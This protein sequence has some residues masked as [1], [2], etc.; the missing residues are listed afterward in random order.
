MEKIRIPKQE[1]FGF[2]EKPSNRGKGTFKITSFVA[3]REDGTT[4]GACQTYG[5]KREFLKEAMEKG[6]LLEVEWMDYKPQFNQFTVYF[7]GG[8]GSGATFRK[9]FEGG[10]GSYY[11]G[12][13]VRF[14]DWL[15]TTE[16]VY[17]AA[18]K[19]AA[20]VVKATQ[21]S[22][23]VKE[24]DISASAAVAT[25]VGEARSLVAQYWMAVERN[26]T[27]VPNYEPP[28]RQESPSGGQ[29][30]PSAP[31]KTNA[32]FEEIKAKIPEVTTLAGFEQLRDEINKG[33]TEGNLT[34][35]QAPEL[36]ALNFQNKKERGLK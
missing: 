30:Q 19:I 21:K 28:V 24:D 4:V 23:G 22:L 29:E 1:H 2:Q 7:P 36:H 12:R 8:S 31:A 16:K 26:V 14:E 17:D 27:F 6:S 13:P 3:E 5:D 18:A 15:V 11:Q 32:L 33:A 34:E 20:S 9:K 10:Y 35:D 25:V